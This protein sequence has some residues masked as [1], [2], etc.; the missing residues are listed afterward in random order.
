MT[1]VYNPVNSCILTMQEHILLGCN[2]YN[3]M[4]HFVFY[5]Y[6]VHEN[7]LYWIED[8]YLNNKWPMTSIYYDEKRYTYWMEVLEHA[9]CST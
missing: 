1:Y 9:H 2:G 6:K 8:Y 3:H 4:L 5:S 7:V